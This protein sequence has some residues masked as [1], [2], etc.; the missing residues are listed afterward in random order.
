MIRTDVA[1]V[2]PD[3]TLTQ[4]GYEVFRG[5]ERQIQ[6]LQADLTVSRVKLQPSVTASG[7]TQINFTGIP[8]WVN[9]ITVI[10]AGLS[11]NGTS[12]VLIRL[13]DSGGIE[14]TGYLSTVAGSS[15]T[16]IGHADQT[17]G[18]FLG[19][20]LAATD[21]I[22][23]RCTISRLSGNTWV[24]DTATKRSTT[25]FIESA[26]DKTL[27]DVLTQLRITTANGTDTFDAGSVAI[28]WE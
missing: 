27:S 11:T 24:A 22:S 28:S 17:T 23:G 9:R 19:A 8:A 12:Q 2:E 7:Q 3:R 26:G 10:A 6:A 13:G 15:G 16:S 4:A 20:P 14:A 18:F 1:Y 21:A 25:A 5:Q